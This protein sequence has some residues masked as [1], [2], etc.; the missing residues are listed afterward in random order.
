MS[1][2]DLAAGEEALSLL[3]EDTK[4]GLADLNEAD[5]RHRFIDRLIHECLGWDRAETHLER[6]YN[7]EYS[8]YEL[9]KPPQIVI[10]AKKA[11]KYFDIPAEVNGGVVRS[12]RSL[13]LMSNE[14]QAAFTQAQKYCSD[15]GIQ[16]AVVTNGTQLVV[17]LGVRNDG[18]PPADGKCLLFNGPSQIQKQFARLWQ[19]ISPH[20]EN[21][22]IL[23]NDLSSSAPTGVPVKLSSYLPGYPSFRYPSTSQQS[24]RTLSDLLIEDAPNT[25]AVRKRFYEECYCESGAL[26]RDAMVGKSILSARYAAMFHPTAEGPTLQSLRGSPDDKFG[27]SAEVVAEAL[28]RRPIVIIGDVGVGKTSFVRNLIYVRAADEIENSIFLY[29]DLG[30][31]ANLGQNLYEFFIEE[32]ERQLLEDHDIDLYEDAFVRGVYHGDLQ[33][34]EK[35]IYGRLKEL[36]PDKFIEKQIEHLNGLV[37][38]KVSH[39]QRCITHF[40][41]G[42]RKQVVICIDNADQ[43]KLDD[44]QQAFLA[45][46]EFAAK[47]LALVLISIRPQTYFAS[48]SSGSISAYPQRILTISP[49]RVD[50]VLQKRLKFSLDLA[51]G[52][53]PLERLANITLKLDSLAL[54]LK[55]LLFSLKTN[56]EISELL[57]NI[58]GGNI[59]EALELI[60]GFIGSSNVNSDKI[61]EI[62]RSDGEYLIPLHE[63]TKQALLG[64]YSHYDSRSSTAY[65]LF[66]IRYPDEKEHFLSCFVIAFLNSGAPSKTTEGFVSTPSVLA[67]MQKYGFVGDQIEHTLRRLTNKKLIETTERITFDEGLQGLVGEMP[68]AFRVTTIGVYHIH[69][70]SASFNYLDAML[71]DTPILNDGT[72]RPMMADIASFDIRHRY[73]RT[74]RFM[75]YLNDCWQNFR[76]WPIYFDWIDIQKGG[77]PTFDSVE[78]AISAR[79]GSKLG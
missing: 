3:L 57:S 38:D 76:D 2:S 21:R 78:R 77:V 1:S 72:R 43:R 17:F 67:E 26:A 14:F 61:I 53:L 52:R 7:G 27:V 66:D 45:A 20:A 24:L 28:G 11:G 63:F 22:K 10:E 56:R 62:M 31:Q 25:P 36:A 65:N 19:A 50:L 30:N 69:R 54:F 23:L 8:D 47:W 34:F 6:R 33:R 51:E 41:K 39:L 75:S 48:K 68:L 55:A 58:T 9:G 49:P 73:D 12:I 13:I 16:I 44:Q 18:I 70:W 60:K 32:I 29:I 4:E 64:E 71:F 37:F 40:S 5:T 79:S 15:R 46:Q 42:R 59:R 35:G 74:V